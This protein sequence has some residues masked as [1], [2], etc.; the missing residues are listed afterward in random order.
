MKL[1]IYQ[2]L[3]L[4]V[5]VLFLLHGVGRILPA[6]IKINSKSVSSCVGN[7]CGSGGTSQSS[8][9]IVN[10][11]LSSI[12]SMIGSS[13]S[14]LSTSSSNLLSNGSKLLPIMN[15]KFNMRECVKQII[16]LEDH[17]FNP[18]KRCQDC[19]KKHFLTIEGLAEEA[20]TL[21][22]ENLV[23]EDADKLA[24]FIRSCQ[25]EYLEQK[26]YSKIGQDLR[27]FRKPYM[28]KYFEL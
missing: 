10:R 7:Q 4:I 15:P 19:I 24:R 3:I 8:P 14:Q 18:Q 16:L 28:Y 6:F 1:K 17:I 26:D 25:K 9:S 5:V 20:L 22:K 21:D 2:V 23:K 27:K 12:S 11:V 13:Y